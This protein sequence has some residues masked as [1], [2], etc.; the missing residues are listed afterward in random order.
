MPFFAELIKAVF[1]FG[2]APALDF[3]K[4][5]FPESVPINFTSS[6]LYGISIFASS[7]T[8]FIPIKTSFFVARK[9]ELL[10]HTATVNS[11]PLSAKPSNQTAGAGSLTT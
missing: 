4:F 2:F 10:N 6:L 8:F 5:S 11:I 1:F 7:K 3:A 9:S